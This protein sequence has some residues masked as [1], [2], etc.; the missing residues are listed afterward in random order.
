MLD[1]EEDAFAFGLEVFAFAAKVASADL[2]VA[3]PESSARL[4]VSVQET[5]GTF[6]VNGDTARGK[7]EDCALSDVGVDEEGEEGDSDAVLDFL[8]IDGL[9]R[10]RERAA[11]NAAGEELED[12]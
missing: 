10:A 4:D 11:N 7:E 8:R 6:I 5:A 12:S 9:P 2:G 3:L 1:G